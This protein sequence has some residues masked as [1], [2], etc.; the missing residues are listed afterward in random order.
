MISSHVKVSFL[1]ISFLVP[2]ITLKFACL[3]PFFF[4][5]SNSPYKDLLFLCGPNL[6]Q[7][8]LYLGGCVLN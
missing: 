1:I 5:D 7:K 8:P 3:P 2:S 4:V 6:V